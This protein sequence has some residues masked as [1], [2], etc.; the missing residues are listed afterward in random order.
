[1]SRSPESQAWPKTLRR[2]SSAAETIGTSLFVSLLLSAAISEALNNVLIVLLFIWW[3]STRSAIRELRPAPLY[4]LIIV[5]FCTT[6]LVSLAT[7]TVGE[8]FDRLRDVTSAIKFALLL[9]PVYSISSGNRISVDLVATCL[10]AGAIIASVEAFVTWHLSSG[11]SPII[12]ALAEANGSALYMSVILGPAIAIS[13]SPKLPI[14]I[15]GYAGIMTSLWLSFISDS[16]T[17]LAVSACVLLLAAVISTFT[18]RRKRFLSTLACFAALSG[19]ALTTTD[20]HFYWKRT[21]HE[22][23]NQVYGNEIGAYRLEI[24]NT[25]AEVYGRN[26]WFGAGY[27]QFRK[28]TTVEIVADELDEDGRNYE[29]ERSRFYHVGHGHNIWTQV[30][31]ERGLVGI[32][33]LLLFFLM[34]AFRICRNVFELYRKG[35][36]DLDLVRLAFISCAVWTMLFVGGIGS[37]TFHTEHGMVALLLLVWSLTGFEVLKSECPSRTRTHYRLKKNRGPTS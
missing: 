27:R 34:T 3:L 16:I 20:A 25:A 12:R 6:P 32:G 22:F 19:V 35:E 14:S 17:A 10:T 26:L 18:K 9:L 15:L 2:G 23:T 11:Y 31:V 28:A 4:L 30:L 5:L 13:W 24:F 1:M 7:S 33:L 21:A 37:S 29:E 8:P 36:H